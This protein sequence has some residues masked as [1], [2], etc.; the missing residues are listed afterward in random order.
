VKMTEDQIE[1]ICE[2]T[3][4]SLDAQLMKG[5]ISQ[6]QYDEEVRQLDIWAKDQYK[7]SETFA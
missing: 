1:F 3:M 4:D 2:K 5:T 7:V 6:A